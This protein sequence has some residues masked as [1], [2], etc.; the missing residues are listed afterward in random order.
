MGNRGT[1][2]RWLARGPPAS[3]AGVRGLGGRDSTSPVFSSRSGQARV[4]IHA[5]SSVIG[6][7]CRDRLP[8]NRKMVI[9]SPFWARVKILYVHHVSSLHDLQTQARGCRIQD[10]LVDGV[11][12]PAQSFMVEIGTPS[13]HEPTISGQRSQQQERELLGAPAKDGAEVFRIGH[14]VECRT[15]QRDFA[16]WLRLSAN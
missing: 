12:G 6:T 11:K 15:H 3:L 9:S 1:S 14:G 10:A 2:W 5:V 13:G 16:W 8:L 4:L 7:R